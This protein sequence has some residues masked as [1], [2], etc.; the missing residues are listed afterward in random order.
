MIQVPHVIGKG[1]YVAT[2]H[3]EPAYFI[4]DRLPT[5]CTM[6]ISFLK[7]C[8]HEQPVHHMMPA[9]QLAEEDPELQSSYVVWPKAG[10]HTRKTRTVRIRARGSSSARG[11]GRAASRG[12]SKGGREGRGRHH[13]SE[14]M[15]EMVE[16]DGG[17][18]AEVVLVPIEGIVASAPESEGL[19]RDENNS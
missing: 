5:L 1:C 19:G 9:L 13:G 8:D 2:G 16:M 17:P 10:K 15:V 11:R 7:L 3:M 4:A 14:G 12:K 6:T 18:T